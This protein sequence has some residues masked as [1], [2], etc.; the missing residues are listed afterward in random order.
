MTNKPKIKICG[1]KSQ[2]ALNSAISGGAQFA[3]FVFWPGSARSV[4]PDQAA[5]LIASGHRRI[6]NVGLFVDPDDSH[7]DSITQ[8][9]G[10]DMIQLHGSEDARRVQAVQ[11]R[12]GLPVIKAIR[13]A[14]HDDLK[15]VEAFE[16]VADWLLFDAKVEGQQGGTGVAFDWGILSGQRFKK[17]W[18]L[19][20]GLNAGNVETALSMLRPDAVD[21][22]SGVEDSPGVKSP[23]KIA[24]FIA[25]I[26]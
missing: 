6:R 20:G 25:K 3:G 5:P 12:T 7:L 4:S 19:S 10:L 17:P 21:V 9:C 23:A 8:R 16:G 11:R 22:S 26:R 18:M 15:Q 13:L 24:D 2:E 1:I 14:V